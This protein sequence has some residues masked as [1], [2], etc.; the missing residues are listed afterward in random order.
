MKRK[1]AI[2][3]STGSIGKNL[4]DILKKKINEFEITLLTANKN[5]KL[6]FKQSK[7]LNVKNLIIT[8]EKSFIK[9]TKINKN[10]NIHIFNNF[11]NFNKIFKKKIDY[12]M[13]AISGINGLEPILDIIK[14]TKVIAIANKEAI[15]CGWSLINDKLKKTKT[16]F[17][18][19]DSEHYSIWFALKNINLKNVEK[20]YITA[21]G[22]PFLN[23]PKA[24]FKD[25]KISDALKHPNWK[26]GKKI[27]VDSA[28]MM[29]KTFEII[30]AKN[31]FNL[32]Y[33]KLS[34][35][36]HKGSYIH[37]II[38]FNT[39]LI[40]IVAHDTT[41][42]I[43]IFNTLYENHDNF[44]KTRQINIQKLNNLELHK[45]D[46]SKFPIQKILKRMPKNTSLF[47]TILV[48][49][50]DFLVEHFLKNKIKFIDINKLLFKIINLKEF[51]KYKTLKVKNLKE[52]IILNNYVRLKLEK[53][54]YKITV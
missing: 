53:Y 38:K 6:L 52:I 44:L 45:I 27:S 37:A 47:E 35:L 9:A 21:S 11:K 5:Y 23:L 40:K 43:P 20:I 3:G 32:P 17:I 1:I 49:A 39:G 10:K 34:V 2:L 28:T 31:I 29:N 19:V 24:K 46:S 33:E 50:N 18:P 42:Q 51:K 13:C 26:M 22:G 12:S 7:L 41:M 48:S 16:K 30:E 36:V 15:I 8:D 14:H 25:I 54:V 4:V